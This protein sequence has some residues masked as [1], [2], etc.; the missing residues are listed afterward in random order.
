VGRWNIQFEVLM[1]KIRTI[2]CLLPVAAAWQAAA[3]TWDTS[4]NG[5]LSGAYYF[6][7]VVWVA[8]DNAGDL[9]EAVSAYG[10]ISFDGNGHY[11]ISNQSINDSAN[12]NTPTNNLSVS[13]TY[14][15]A[16]SGYGSISSP[17]SN[18]DSV[19]GL[20]SHGIF[21]GS[22]TDNGSG[23]ND[24]FVAAQLGSPAP[25]NASFSGTYNMVDIDFTAAGLQGSNVL[26]NRQSTFQL[27]PNGG[28]SIPSVSLAGY[29]AGSGTKVINQSISS[30]PYFASGGALNLNFGSKA[31]NATDTSHLIAGT[32]YLYISPDGNFVFGGDPQYAWDMILGV[33]QGSGTPNF[34]GLYYQAGVAVDNSQLANGGIT[35]WTQYGSLNDSSGVLLA[36]Q[37]YLDAI[38]NGGAV[39]FTYSDVATAN[40][41]GTYSD[42]FNKY[43]FGGGGAI[44][45]GI[46]TS[47]YFAVTALVQGPSF[48]APNSPFIFPT[49]IVNAGS[50]APFTASLAPGE[51]VSIY[52]TNLTSTTATDGTL[53]T[54]L[55][56]VQVLVNNTAA[57]IYS[58]AHTSSYDQINAVIPLGTTSIIA[59][60]QVTNGSGSS[61]TVTSYVNATQP[62]AFNSFTATPAVQH[63]A[64]YSLVT[65]SNPARVGETLLVYLTG[66]GTLGTMTSSG[67]L[68]NSISADID[69]IPATVAFAGTQ[70]TV[71]GG[72]QMNVVVPSGITNN[73]AYLDIVGPDSDNE[74]VAIPI[75]IG[76][77]GAIRSSARIARPKRQARSG[78]TA[79]SRRQQ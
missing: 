35:L 16:A 73:P 41:D 74:E 39:D 23:Y 26:Y 2:A 49:G 64:D 59:A 21:I 55:A 54:S 65:P 14:A 11:T 28:G 15:I 30:V 29:V 48:T 9:Q 32:K 61:N 13:G 70:S 51:L 57:P 69:F 33:K 50:S 71:G 67:N 25:T 20:V 77:A 66:L 31:L 62:G 60:V 43:F 10:Q 34:N 68:N 63:G 3:Q 38:N 47:P 6:R 7:Q 12:N 37:R 5:L 45:V 46:G 53:P 8:G 78:A 19:Y 36:H 17:V 72:Y 44:G 18:G 52:G 79:K 27:R 4:G 40:G 1:N 42:S 24:M 76:T 22:S 58:V 75:A 56:G